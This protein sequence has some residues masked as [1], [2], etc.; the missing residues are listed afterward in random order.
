MRTAFPYLRL[1][2]QLTFKTNYSTAYTRKDNTTENLFT[3]DGLHIKKKIKT[4]NI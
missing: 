4:K 3:Y 1:F 2:E